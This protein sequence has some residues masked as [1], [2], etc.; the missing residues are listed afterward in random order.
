MYGGPER[1]GLICTRGLKGHV[2]AC[3]ATLLSNCL[4]LYINILWYYKVTFLTRSKVF[5][6][7]HVHLYNVCS[8]SLPDEL[9]QPLTYKVA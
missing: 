1:S 6:R 3:I 2:I 9:K 7:H 4:N 5:L 8:F